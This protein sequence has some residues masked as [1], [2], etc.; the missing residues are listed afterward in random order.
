MKKIVAFTGPAGVGKD[1]AADYLSAQGFQR[2]AFAQGLKDMLAAI[3][4]PEPERREYKEFPDPRFLN[5][6]YRRAAQTLGTEWGRG[7][8]PDFWL[9]VATNRILAMPDDVVVTDCRFENEAAMV[10]DLGGLV[11]HLSG[12]G[13]ELGA[14]AAHA[15]EGGVRRRADLGDGVIENVGTIENLRMSV[16]GLV[17]SKYGW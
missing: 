11:I 2:I 10:R 8:H 7:L 14:A 13:V 17:E 6:S 16:A 5:V 15:S 4:W 9:M 3:G 1:T 12:R